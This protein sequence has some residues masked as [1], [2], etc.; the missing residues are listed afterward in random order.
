[1]QDE[2]G[3][4]QVP[5]GRPEPIAPSREARLR[6]YLTHMPYASWCRWCV[7]GRRNNSP[8]FKSRDGSDR[9]LPLLVLD[10]CFVRSEEDDDRATVLVAKLYPSR[11]MSDCVLET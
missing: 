11:K 1:M 7:Q 10:Y 2:L 6:H 3:K 5:R 9:A 4:N 8:D